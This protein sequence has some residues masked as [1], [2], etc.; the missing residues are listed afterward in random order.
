MGQGH[1]LVRHYASH[2]ELAKFTTDLLWPESLRGKVVADIG[3]G[4]GSLL[5]HIGGVAGETI[6][7]EPD[8]GFAE[9]LR[10]RGYR[11]YASAQDCAA[12]WRRK[13]DIAFAIQVIEHVS[14]PRRFLEG[15]RDLLAPGGKL[16]VS[17]PNRRDILLE[18]LPDDFPPFFYRTQHRWYFDEPSLR[19]AAQAAGLKVEEIR[20]V[21]RY[22]MANTL[23]WLRDRRP[24][25]RTALIAV[26]RNAD[27][28]WRNWLEASGRAD[29]LYA[30]LGAA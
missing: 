22:G 6:A 21:H 2:D 20:H 26:D 9:S 8:R 14:E 3:C 15:C 29:N 16:I 19:L 12:E 23:L 11:W 25:G 13:V 28:M 7:V 4:G 24:R 30:V 27:N 5:D 17:T 10:Q 18:L 1:D